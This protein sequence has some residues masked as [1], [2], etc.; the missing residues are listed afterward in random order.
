MQSYNK[1]KSDQISRPYLQ[2]IV[3]RQVH[4]VSHWGMAEYSFSAE[5]SGQYVQ[6]RGNSGSL[7]SSD[8]TPP[9]SSLAAN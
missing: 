3:D 2:A 7:K 1:M 8:G 4:G 6:D 5:P 9:R